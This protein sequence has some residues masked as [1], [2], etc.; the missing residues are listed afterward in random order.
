M[1]RVKLLRRF[2]HPPEKPLIVPPCFD[3]TLNAHPFVDN[4]A[5][6]MRLLKNRKPGD[7]HPWVTGRDGY[8]QCEG[9]TRE[10]AKTYL[11]TTNPV[12]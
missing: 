10:M 5:G 6:L 8:M 2:S 3:V 7:P 12:R 1:R 9:A 11:A 4:T